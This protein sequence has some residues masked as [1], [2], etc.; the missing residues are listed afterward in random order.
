MEASAIV[1]R[2]ALASTHTI[3]D[4]DTPQFIVDLWRRS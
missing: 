4:K 1:T 2:V 3:S